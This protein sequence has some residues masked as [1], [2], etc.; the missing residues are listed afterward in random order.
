MTS[1]MHV[2]GPLIS[3]LPAL[4]KG[5]TSVLVPR[6]EASVVLDTIERFGC[7]NFISLPWMADS[8]VIEQIA[9][10]HKVRSL[11]KCATAGDVVSHDL[12][13]RFAESFGLPLL[14]AF[15]MTEIGGAAANSPAE[16]RPGSFGKPLSGFSLRVVDSSGNDLPTGETGELIVRSKATCS[17]YWNNPEATN[18]ALH[19]GWFYTGD[20]ARQD[21][22]SYFWFAGRKKDLIV[23]MGYKVTPFEVEQVLKA[24]K[25][26]AEAGVVGLPDP[27]FGE[28]VIALIKPKNKSEFNELELLEFAGQS[29]ADYKT[30]E[31][32]LLFPELP[33]N[34]NGKVDR[35]A[36]K[37][38]AA[39]LLEGSELEDV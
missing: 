22:D 11:R 20:L 30:P 12:Q 6:F 7:T 15:G 39:T 24:H 25:S 2:V 37:N 4:S 10:P 23:R 3:L 21:E 35:P 38:L 27:S 16:N 36:L 34:A 32:I 31:R 14:E 29:L 17:G 18:E 13:K 33:K 19:D 5:A 26:V 9:R 8:L 28:R 1:L